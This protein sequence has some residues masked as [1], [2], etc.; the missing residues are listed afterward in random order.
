[1]VET[2]RAFTLRVLRDRIEGLEEKLAW[3]RS[4]RE[5]CLLDPDENLDPRKYGWEDPHGR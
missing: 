1:M 5:R 2:N 3:L 4:E